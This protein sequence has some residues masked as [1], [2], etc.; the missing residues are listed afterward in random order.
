MAGDIPPSSLLIP[1]TEP[2]WHSSICAT[3]RLQKM[4]RPRVMEDSV[5]EIRPIF[6]VEMKRVL[7]YADWYESREGKKSPQQ[8]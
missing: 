2:P 8:R 1:Y 7:A 4:K 6:K 3:P 5:L